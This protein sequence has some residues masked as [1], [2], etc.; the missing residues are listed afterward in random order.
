MR[1]P[2][3]SDPGR[4][5]H[6][7]DKWECFKAG[8]YATCKEGLTKQEC[9]QQYVELLANEELFAEVARKVI[10]AWPMSC[11]HYL[12]NAAMNRLAW[13][14]QAAVCLHSG[15]PSK[16]SG[17]WSLLTPEQQDAANAVAMVV[18]NEWLESRGILPL[19][20]E[21]AAAIGRQVEIY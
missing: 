19:G 5:F 11:E 21:E 20:I 13:I 6:T 12:T 14:G 8:F 4:V 15:V 10:T 3:T 2:N 16:Y 18:L 7:F 9:E 17:G 1:V